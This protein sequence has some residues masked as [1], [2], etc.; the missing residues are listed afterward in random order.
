M[1]IK[2]I[3]K[4]LGRIYSI[5]IPLIAWFEYETQKAYFRDKGY[6]HHVNFT[7]AQYANYHK[8]TLKEWINE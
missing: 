7:Y 1:T 5:F 3:K 6:P 4:G 8:E 2:K